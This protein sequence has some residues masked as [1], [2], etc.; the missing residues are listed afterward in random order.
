MYRTKIYHVSFH[1]ALSSVSLFFHGCNFTC[2]GC[3]RRV[4]M[5][6]CHL[7]EIPKT[8]RL[9]FL[10]IDKLIEILEK[11]EPKIA[12]FEGWE[13]TLDPMLAE[14]ADSIRNNEIRTVLLTNGYLYPPVDS[15]DEIKVSIK[16]FSHQVHK[17][18]TGKSNRRVLRN[19]KSIYDNAPEKL[20]AETVLIPG[21]V[22]IDEIESIAKFIS[23]IDPTIPL[24][25]DCYW[26]VV[27][28]TP[29]RAPTRE[30]IRSAVIR[31]RKYLEN[32][33]FLSSDAKIIGKVRNLW[34]IE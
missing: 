24:R 17:Y 28:N 21:L 12:V 15:F 18:Y 20:S 34:P 29:W 4:Y 7:S 31:A 13:P 14:I 2:K 25:I 27:P 33:H 11:T 32:V 26:P 3:L 23:S 9:N 1:E 6:D 16:A 5:Y 19:F 8:S 10:T 22:D 30:E